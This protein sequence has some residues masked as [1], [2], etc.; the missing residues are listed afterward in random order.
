MLEHLGF[1]NLSGQLVAD[2]IIGPH[3]KGGAGFKRDFALLFSEMILFVAAGTKAQGKT[4]C[5]FDNPGCLFIIQYF[6]KILFGNRALVR[7]GSQNG[8]FPP[9]GSV[10]GQ[11]VAA[12]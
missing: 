1:G 4:I 3:I 9:L 2:K 8:N 11:E 6:D 12:M 10:G 7:Q 5:T